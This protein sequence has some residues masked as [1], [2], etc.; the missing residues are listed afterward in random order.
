MNKYILEKYC[1]FKTIENCYILKN[2][3]STEKYLL[4]SSS[5][6]NYSLKIKENGYIPK[7]GL[8]FQNIIKDIV[9]G[10][11]VL[12][13]GAGQLGIIGIHS[14]LSGASNVTAVDIDCECVEWLNVLIKENDFKN[15]ETKTSNLFENLSDEK[16]DIIFSNPPQ[17]PMINGNFHDS[18]GIDGRDYILK[19][20][21]YSINHLN[22]NGEVYIL[23]F[24]FLGTTI[25]TNSNTT[26]I[27]IAKD[28]GYSQV[29]IV[30]ET[31]KIIKENSVTFQNLEY[32]ND[33]LYFNIQ[34]V[35][36]LK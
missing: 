23:I 32:I 4:Y 18:G 34:I 25:K 24:D 28:I 29:E 12:D 33:N 5:D 9:K 6:I 15:I 2:Q 3:I 35:K 17:M 8:I 36:F 30:S 31:P 20:L 14:L 26:I 7:S 21:K 16:F 11:K 22:E 10:K 13:L 1:P 19:I 27:D